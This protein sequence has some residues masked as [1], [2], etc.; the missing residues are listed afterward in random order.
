MGKIL[1]ELMEEMKDQKILDFHE[2]IMEISNNIFNEEKESMKYIDLHPNG[3][4]VI[5][6]L[7]TKGLIKKEIGFLT[8]Q[9]DF[10]DKYICVYRTIFEPKIKH[11]KEND[12]V[13]YFINATWEIDENKV[14]KVMKEFIK[15]YKF[16]E[17]K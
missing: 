7:E 8:L 16:I 1:D 17:G 4:N 2:Q 13:R 14:E 11:L 5:L 15:R 3:A 9:R 12:E 10:G 6:T